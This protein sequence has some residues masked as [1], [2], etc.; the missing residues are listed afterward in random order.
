MKLILTD[1]R[2]NKKYIVYTTVI[3]SW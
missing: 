1:K 3:A 2:G